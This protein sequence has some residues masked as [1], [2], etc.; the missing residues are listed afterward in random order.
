MA[1]GS[2]RHLFDIPDDVAYLNTAYQGPLPRAS[3]M[4][5]QEA[6]ARKG[7]P[8]LI[9]PEDFF[10]PVEEYRQLVARLLGADVDGVAVTPSISYGLA[11]AA[12]NLPFAAGQQIV[13]LAG[14]FPSNVYGWRALAER[15]DGH[16]H[17]V[18]RPPDG[19]WTTAVLDHLERNGDEVAIAA[20]P[21][22]HW[23]D[24]AP[25]DVVPIGARCRELGTALV[26]DGAQSLG[27]VPFPFEQVQPA[28]IAG[29][30]YKWL[31]GPYSLGFVWVAPAWR[32]G[33]PIEHNWI[34]RAGSDRFSSLVDYVDE[35]QPGA[36]RYDMGEVSNFGLIPVASESL[37]TLLRWDGAEVAAHA[38]RLTD[39][40]ADGARDLGFEVAPATARS[41]HLIGLRR[42]GLDTEGLAGVLAGDRV[43]V[44]VRGDSVRVSAHV[45]NTDDDADRLVAALATVAARTTS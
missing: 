42:P 33:A 26:V 7:T 8:W 27:A 44:S 16:V 22:C 14:E 40:I 2:Q 25:V 29:A 6:L 17:T 10:A 18:D 12:A 37:R 3:V 38:R 24:G 19:D 39:R 30:T 13:V 28:F 31:L 34:T 4:Q 45:F 11:V 9:T 20:V 1:L 43:H 15:T 41:D 23:T 35:F 32:S 21:A 36:R 5:G